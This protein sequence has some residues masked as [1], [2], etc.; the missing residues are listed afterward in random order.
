MLDEA[1]DMLDDR[2]DMLDEACDMLDAPREGAPR[3]A[4]R[5]MKAGGARAANVLDVPRLQALGRAEGECAGDCR[6]IFAGFWIAS[7]W[8]DFSGW[9][10]I[11]NP[12]IELVPRN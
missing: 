4:S 2:C 1:C 8:G 3:S 6:W 7:Y 10:Q 9:L 12:C 5:P 11:F